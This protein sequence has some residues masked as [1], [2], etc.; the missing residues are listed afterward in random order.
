[1]LDFKLLNEQIAIRQEKTIMNFVWVAA[2]NNSQIFL[3]FCSF[4]KEYFLS[5]ISICFDKPPT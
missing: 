3:V 5:Q 4:A 1:M 2:G